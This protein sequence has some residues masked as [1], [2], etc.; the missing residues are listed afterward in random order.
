MFPKTK[1]VEIFWPIICATFLVR[2]GV[3]VKLLSEF[4][5][6]SIL[7]LIGTGRLPIKLV[8][9]CVRYFLSNFYFFTK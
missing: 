4:K 3:S 5:I 6:D 9:A 2:K 7:V 1:I 8:K